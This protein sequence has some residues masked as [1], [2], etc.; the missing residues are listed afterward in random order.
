MDA[1]ASG[2]SATLLVSGR[3]R[4]EMVRLVDG[5]PTRR[6]PLKGQARG[7]SLAAIGDRFAALWMDE[8]GG[9]LVMQWFDGMLTPLGNPAT[10]LAAAEGSSFLGGRLVAG[11][12]A[13]LA[14]VA[15]QRKNGP[16]LVSHPRTPAHCAEDVGPDLGRGLRSVGADARADAH[17]LEGAAARD[18][19]GWLGD[20][21]LV[22][23]GAES[24]RIA[25]FAA[26]VKK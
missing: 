1:V 2:A 18:A 13:R 10:L 19:C 26:V 17:S 23:H 21:L 11:D 3:D 5:R 9:R 4:A 6:T 24:P 12:P 16:G 7:P 15:G 20:V 8:S 14:L 25:P 22:V